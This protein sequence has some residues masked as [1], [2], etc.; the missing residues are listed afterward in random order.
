[1]RR[2]TLSFHVLTGAPSDV[3]AGE[4]GSKWCVDQELSK[5][6]G[7][8]FARAGSELEVFFKCKGM[9]Y[10]VRTRPCMNIISAHDACA[11]LGIDVS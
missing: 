7:V 1:M 9:H 11:N 4:A 8:R 3:S 6:L 5:H 10:K 2:P